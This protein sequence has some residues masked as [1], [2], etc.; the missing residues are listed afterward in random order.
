VKT[1]NQP[2][3]LQ[4]RVRKAIGTIAAVLGCLLILAF[5]AGTANAQTFQNAP[6]VTTLFAGVQN[7]TVTGPGGLTV[8]TSGVIA[9][10]TAISQFT[11]GP[12]GADGKFAC[13]EPGATTACNTVRHIWYGDA[14]NGLCRIDPEVDANLATPV[15]GFGAWNVNALACVISINKLA[16]APGQIT[17]DSQHQLMYLTNVSR[18][19]AGIARIIFHP[20][21]D[22]G[23]GMVDLIQV[24]SLIGTQAGRNAFG[25]CGQ[26]ANPK[27]GSP[28]PRIPDALAL[29]PDGDLY[30]GD[31]RDGAILRIV[32][33]A[34]FNT[35]TDCP[36][37]TIS[38]SGFTGQDPTQKIQI[39]I[40]AHDSLFGSGHTFGLGFI[41]DTLIGA[42]NIAPWVQFHAT[43]CLT[44]VNGNTTCGSPVVGGA[45]IPN[46]I[47][48]SAAGAPQGGLASDAQYPFFPGNAVYV[49]SFPNLT[50][51]T[52]I[53]SGSQQTANLN[54]GGSFS[55]LTGVTADPLD[56]ANATV[57][58]G[59][60]ETQGGI[61]GTGRLW[62]ITPA[63]A[64]PGPPATP[65]FTSAAAGPGTGQA[66]L[67]WVPT[68]NGQPTTTY[69]ISIWLA[70]PTGGAATPSGLPDVVF[71]AP[72]QSAT[73]SGLT[74]GIGYQFEIEACN[75]AGCS[76]FSPLSPIVTPFTTTVPAQPTGVVGVS[77]G[78]GSTIAVA[79][80]VPSNGHSPVTSSAITVFTGTPA[81]QVGSPVT[82]LGA[83]TG[84]SVTGLACSPTAS[85][86]FSVTATNAVGA[87]AASALS[88]PVPNPC[89]THAD[90]SA[91]ETVQA[92]S[93]AGAQ[94]TYTITMHN[95]GPAVAPSVGFSD[96]LPAGYV[97][98]TFSQGICTGTVT[99]TTFNCALGAIPVAGSATVTVT[100]LLPNANGSFT[101]S[102]TVNVTDPANLVSDGNLTNN[103]FS[104]TTTVGGGGGCTA[105]AADIQVVGSANN[106]NPPHGS[107]VTFTWQIKNGTGNVGA[108]CVNFTAV[109]T[110]PSGAT[111]LQN[112]FTTTQGTCS[113]DAS[114]NLS[115]NL[116][117]M[118][119]GGAATVTVQATPSAAEPANSYSTTGSATS[120]GTDPNTA[121]NSSTVH[122]GAQ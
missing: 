68:V 91:S 27:T 71:N 37:G 73:I 115:C 119:G 98:S 77:A 62:R 58:A 52:N 19:G 110:A 111:L 108:N 20:E 103:T 104:A 97:S 66:T 33:A 42:D 88:A 100:V 47:L 24:D 31:I 99:L 3:F 79:W 117:N 63:P 114:N 43:Q 90:V 23:Q 109:T 53:L 15:G 21:G 38:G 18:V 6:T 78:D 116:G 54:Y 48:A 112:S 106:G 13:Q 57:Y 40:L 67:G 74:S 44:P 50:R 107:P 87:S 35:Q 83:G 29:G 72:A 70:S 69:D 86:Q 89:A 45:P 60:D 82:I 85:Y 95:N 56:P 105:S 2:R 16:I 76:A 30:A 101:N 28:V 4:L 121:N 22:N 102:A 11:N 65:A 49:A 8:P 59:D 7:V 75:A 1:P 80:T 39:P 32:G 9:N 46:E 10:G 96:T 36:P 26:L 93:N 41:G 61:N 17:Y 12:L 113:I 51:V 25:G 64:A 14:I 92:T 34:T 122:I 94:V 84:G 120:T 118:A 55:F 5:A 81:V